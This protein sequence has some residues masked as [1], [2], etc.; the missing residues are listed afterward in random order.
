MKKRKGLKFNYIKM[1]LFVITTTVIILSNKII[2]NTH[3]YNQK[4]EYTET[5]T[6]KNDV[7]TEI[8][9]IEDALYWGIQIDYNGDYRVID[10]AGLNYINKNNSNIEY[11]AEISMESGKEFLLSNLSKVTVDTN[12]MIE[13][14]KKEYLYYQCS[15]NSSPETNMDFL[16][17]Y[18]FKADQGRFKIL[19]IYIR[20]NLENDG[21]LKTKK[22]NYEREL[23][24]VNLYKIVVIILSIAFIILLI[25]AI[26]KE[27]KP[28]NFNIK[29][30]A[31]LLMLI[32]ASR[33]Y[34]RYIVLIYL[35]IYTIISELFFSAIRKIKKAKKDK[36]E[37]FTSIIKDINENYKI[38][39][40][41][42]ILTILVVSIIS[43]LTHNMEI[44]IY[45]PNTKILGILLYIAILISI[46]KS[47]AEYNKI[48]KGIKNISNGNYEIRLETES[49]Q[50]KD[51]VEDINKIKDGMEKA[52]NEKVK[53]ERL[54]TDLIT[55]VSHDLKTPLTSIINYTNLLKKENVANENAQKYIEIL[56]NKSKKLKNLTE[57]L[58]EASKISSGNETVNLE[59]LNFAEMIL[60]AN[61]EFAEK[62]ESK[63]LK[64]I[65]KIEKEEIFAQLDS[66][67]MWRVLENIYN[68]AYK[69]S[70][71]GTRIYVNVEQNEKIVFTMKNISKEELDITP[72]E[73]MERF[74]RGDKS[75]TSSGNGLGLSI[76]KDLVNL[77]GG[78]MQIKIEGDL[79]IVKIVI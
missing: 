63:D 3:K 21:H 60:Q 23:T 45:D 30:L 73:L 52:V 17:E 8:N 49:L 24:L 67:K 6:F 25:V 54:K 43:G 58:I 34:N 10:Y 7:L 50:F 32:I 66:K 37:V 48:K 16:K 20:V 2:I 53:S 5:E 38:L 77:Q 68:N 72:A 4:K 61:G 71:E 29:I 40:I 9:T 39:I 42:L 70:L 11:I 19:N 78:E 1:I 35:T 75:R 12:R 33:T 59:R 36:E 62:Y 27:E 44:V 55:N 22:E 26:K 41:L 13:E 46:I 31:I 74:V 69:Y 65:S 79:F 57:D 15:L 14:F 47:S 18:K 51:L 64:L 56:E 28:S 76:A